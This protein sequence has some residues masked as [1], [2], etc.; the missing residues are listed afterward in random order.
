V[1]AAEA[2]GKN[3]EKLDECIKAVPGII[4]KML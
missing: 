4:E 1:S 2:G 3:P